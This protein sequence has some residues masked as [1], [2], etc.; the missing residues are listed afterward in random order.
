M[1]NKKYKMFCLPKNAQTKNMEVHM[2]KCALLLAALLIALPLASCGDS[3]ETTDNTTNPAASTAAP[4]NNTSVTTT[5]DAPETTT[6]AET[7]ATTTSAE[8]PE[9][10]EDPE[11]SEVT[12]GTEAP[13]TTANTDPA[14]TTTPTSEPAVSEPAEPS[15][16]A[17]PSEPEESTTGFKVGTA[18]EL[19]AAILAINDLEAPEDTNITLTADIDLTGYTDWSSWEPLYRYSGTF[20]GAGHTIKNLKW[21]FTM[22]ND[23]NTNMPT[24]DQDYS[25]VLENMLDFPIGGNC[26]ARATVSLLILEL[27]GGTVK[28]LTLSDSSLTIHCSYNKNYLM[29]FGTVVGYMN[30]GTISNVNLTNVDMTI[31]EQVNYNHAFVGYAAPLVGRVTGVATVSGCKADAKCLV[32]ASAN[33]KMNTGKLIGIMDDANGSL[34]LSG[35]AS[36]AETKVHPNPTADSLMYKGNDTVLGG[37]AGKELVGKDLSK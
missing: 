12:T 23:G 4:D 19:A 15:V 20:D 2:K 18:K 10:T 25:Y 33:V 16:P 17:E 35:C 32:D 36:D 28:D 1:Y 3:S 13:E 31:P 34:K 26:A 7:P 22:S 5:T 14:E 6:N 37:V 11:T 27:D 24:A 30:G 29:H 8:T 21:N 9:T